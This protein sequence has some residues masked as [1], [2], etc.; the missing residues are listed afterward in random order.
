[1]KSVLLGALLGGLVVFL[2]GA[3][4]HMVL[5]SPGAAGIHGLPQEEHVVSALKGALLEPGFYA[6]PWTES[7][8]PSA[9]EEAAWEARYRAGP[10]GVVIYQPSGAEPLSARQLATELASNVLG[11]LLAAL[12][13]RSSGLGYAGRVLLV[14]SLGLFAWL[15]ID[16]SYWNWYRFPTAFARAGLLDAVVGWLL[17]GLVLAYVVKPRPAL[18]VQP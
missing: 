8:D 7:A 18:A 12:V 11:A 14:A 5:L 15:A 10:T 9:E 4:A 1:V 16:V 17:A 6:F 2:W 13:L 3:V